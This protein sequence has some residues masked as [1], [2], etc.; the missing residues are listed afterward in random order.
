LPAISPYV[1]WWLLLA[2]LLLCLLA[3]LAWYI[4]QVSLRRMPVPLFFLAALLFHLLFAGGLFFVAVDSELAARAKKLWEDAVMTEVATTSPQTEQPSYEKVADLD[5]VETVETEAVARQES[6]AP[7]VEL[8]PEMLARAI[9]LEAARDLAPHEKIFIEPEPAKSVRSEPQLARRSLAPIEI[10][11]TVPV[12]QPQ[13]PQPDRARAAPPAEDVAIAKS[14]SPVA[15]DVPL[16]SQ[17]T[18]MQSSAPSETASQRVAPNPTPTAGSAGDPALARAAPLLEPVDA[19]QVAVEGVASEAAE[20]P[21]P[22]SP[23]ENIALDRAAAALQSNVPAVVTTSAVPRPRAMKEIDATAEKITASS[24]AGSEHALTLARADTA[25]P[26][27]AA[28]TIDV[29]SSQQAPSTGEAKPQPTESVSV[30]RSSTVVDVN[31]ADMAVGARPTSAPSSTPNEIVREVGDVT[32]KSALPLSSPLASRSLASA[33][34]NDEAVP[35][36]TADSPPAPTSEGPRDGSP[37]VESLAVAVNRAA[38][39]EIAPARLS[40]GKSAGSTTPVAG[41]TSSVAAKTAGSTSPSARPLSSPLKRALPGDSPDAGAKAIAAEE[42]ETV[43]IAA[44][45]SPAKDGEADGS[46]AAVS[47]ARAGGLTG[48]F[49]NPAAST[50]TGGMP[51]TLARRTM[52]SR[53]ESVTMPS[54]A[55]NLDLGRLA[56][57]RPVLTYA[58]SNI[59]L[60]AMFRLRRLDAET[61]RDL[62]KAFGGSN[63]TLTAI[64][65]GLVWLKNH[66]AEDGRWSLHE[67]DKHGPR[68]KKSG[69]AGSVKSDV[70]GTGFALLPFLGDGH[71]HQEGKYR[72]VVARGVR[73]LVEN[74]QES[75]EL[76]SG[77]EGN[78]RMYSHGVAAIALCEVYGMTR[79]PQLHDPAQRAI[80]FIVA[81]QH[82][83]SGGWRYQPNQDGDTSVV[84]WQ[85]M[86]LKSAQMA[87]LEV[88]TPTLAGADRWLDGVEGRGKDRGQYRYQKGRGAS[89]TMTAEALLCREYLGSPRSDRSVAAAADY[90]LA[91]LPRK[92]KDSSYYWYYGTQAMF[93]LQGEHWQRWNSA[94]QPVLLTTQEVSGPAAGTWPPKDNW[95]RSGGRL[96]ATSLRLLMLEVGYRHLPLYQTLD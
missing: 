80:D 43:S 40:A 47:V 14:P 9:P 58:E 1:G 29:D 21:S 4:R 88:P 23:R 46:S 44:T 5:K 92:D 18:Q 25:L 65:R 89:P 30:A 70:A 53:G 11:T 57:K 10:E 35:I 75:G 19:P 93:H 96:Y 42:I 72:A 61:K 86:A 54:R 76:T 33:A 36:E 83:K 82:T 91:H 13:A 24:P 63:Q 60:E 67:F 48:E 52:L 8:S 7:Q 90:L 31:V 34:I 2:L 20:T 68:G 12:E 49:L 45:P 17:S 3:A 38:A 26:Q 94:I 37:D 85:V 41:P 15:T 27:S 77:K 74:Q 62:V 95:E 16:N 50:N 79:D 28:E 32:I 59:G 6:N 71:T 81:A 39:G 78:A 73:W 55:A 64:A 51:R 84:G 56:M 87:G 22:S 66:Q 69:G